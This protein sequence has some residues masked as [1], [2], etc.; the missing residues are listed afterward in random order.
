MAQMV[1]ELRVQ[2]TRDERGLLFVAVRRYG[3]NER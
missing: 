1:Q 2:R 3:S